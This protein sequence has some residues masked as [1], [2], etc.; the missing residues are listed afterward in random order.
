MSTETTTEERV[1]EVEPGNT[2]F[3][4]LRAALA[5]ATEGATG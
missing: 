4:A 2:I 5:A 3:L 1:K